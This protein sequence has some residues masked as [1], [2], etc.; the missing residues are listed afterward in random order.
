MMRITISH[1]NQ[2]I[3]LQLERSVPEREAFEAL[4]AFSISAFENLPEDL[5]F[6][7]AGPSGETFHLQ[8]PQDWKVFLDMVGGIN[9]VEF[10][11]LNETMSTESE[12]EESFEIIDGDTITGVES[13]SEESSSEGNLPEMSI[14]SVPAEDEKIVEPKPT[15]D[16][17]K[18]NVEDKPK[19]VAKETS[20]TEGETLSMKQRMAQF[21]MD[22]GTEDMQNITVVLHSLLVDG[23]DIPTAVRLAM[24]TSET[25]IAHPFVQT[26]FSMTAMFAPMVQN[27][28]P[29]L[30]QFDPTHCVAMLPQIIEAITRAAQGER[31]VEVNIRNVFPA[32]V[33]AN[34]E[35]MIP[36]GEERVFS[37]IPGAPFSVIDEAAE[38]IEA[39]FGPVHRNVTCDGCGKEGIVGT[40]YK[41]TVCPDFDLCENCEPEHDR[42]HPMIKINEPLRE[43]H[44]PGMWEFM[45]ATGGRR[46]RCGG[47]PGRGRH[48]GRPGRGRCGGDRGQRRFRGCGGGRGR[49]RRCH[50]FK[51]PNSGPCFMKHKMK[52]C[53]EKMNENGFFDQ[54]KDSPCFQKMQNFFGQM[55]D[56]KKMHKKNKMKKCFEKMKENGFFDQ[57]MD[58]PCFKKMQK[59]F[60]QGE[61]NE[62][63]PSAPPAEQRASELKSQ[64][65]TIKEEAKKA[66]AELK[67]KKKEK[68]MMQKELKKVKKEAKK[69]AKKEQKKRFASEVVAHL[70]LEEN[71]TQVAG[72]YVLKTWKVKNTGFVAWGEDT[73]AT[74]KKGNEAMVTPDSFNVMVGSVAPGEVTYIRAMFSVPTEAGTHKVVYRLQSPEAGKFGA[75]MKTFITVEAAA[76]PAEEEEPVPEPEPVFAEPEPE[77]EVFQYPDALKLLQNM[78]FNVEQ[79]KAALVA[80]Q[81]D[82][83]G[84]I[85]ILLN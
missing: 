70:D 65:Q 62:S 13:A 66:R 79:S 41:C 8:D 34:L 7:Y 64:I 17:T 63:A 21:L 58:S 30:T 82:A 12:D 71:S 55:D 80:T 20:A 47:F 60:E 84:A 26:I 5:V 16:T 42:S 44:T 11:I 29:M 56:Q 31:D 61:Q 4:S 51:G 33:I 38:A 37:C 49:G 46:G 32:E 59:H 81:G 45:K 68:K 6:T 57:H 15:L 83:N 1:R 43:M 72:T 74:F 85:A 19:P 18:Q 23:H 52:K 54:H 69:E 22:V 67:E 76:E 27:W 35:Q 53:F 24:E 3:S 75:P 28:V 10:K 2:K 9:D 39:E 78:G 50:G 48:G 25:A 40:R 14:E 77:E 36:E 73:M